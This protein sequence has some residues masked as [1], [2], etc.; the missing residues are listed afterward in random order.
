MPQK[1]IQRLFTKEM[2]RKGF[3]AHIGAGALVV[4]GASGLM[5]TLL[6][7]NHMPRRQQV[8]GYSSGSYGGKK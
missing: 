4:I 6:D 3:L 5:K 2:D 8:N 7:Y 1:P